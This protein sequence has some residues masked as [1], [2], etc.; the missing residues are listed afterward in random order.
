MTIF[1]SDTNNRGFYFRSLRTTGYIYRRY[2]DLF[3]EVFSEIIWAKKDELSFEQKLTKFN[4][5]WY[6][7]DPSPGT[8]INEKRDEFLR[9][10]DYTIEN[11][12]RGSMPGWK[13]D[14]GVIYI[15]FGPPDNI[16]ENGISGNL[17]WKY[18]K[19]EIIF[20]FYDK[21]GFKDYDF[22]QTLPID[23]PIR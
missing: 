1:G 7:I 8:E 21:H 12:A 17:Y 18:Y 4:Y 23:A 5:L 11:F 15:M 19:K 10:I 20:R 14:Q 3:E 16:Y 2:L 22:L 6:S 13:T 9:R